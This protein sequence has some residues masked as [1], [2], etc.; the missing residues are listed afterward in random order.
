MYMISVYAGHKWT[1]NV[2]WCQGQC[3]KRFVW[4]YKKRI[5]RRFS[6]TTVDFDEAVGFSRDIHV[7]MLLVLGPPWLGWTIAHGSS[8][9]Y[10]FY[11]AIVVKM[12]W[13]QN[14]CSQPRHEE[15]RITKCM[16]PTPTWSENDH[17]MYN[18]MPPTPI[19]NSSCVKL[20]CIN[21]LFFV[22]M[23]MYIFLPF[24]MKI[25]TSSKSVLD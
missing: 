7:Y 14:I 24:G 23:Y 9:F 17:K 21:L 1:Y 3:K 13:S 22:Y 15:K 20:R 16:R 25:W 11:R 8:L 18:Y 4:S 5:D 10:C 6:D 12:I 2:L 19:H